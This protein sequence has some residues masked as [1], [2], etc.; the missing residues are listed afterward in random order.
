MCLVVNTMLYAF[1]YRHMV[2]YFMRVGG[3]QDLA[4]RLKLYIHPLYIGA[5]CVV[6][7][8]RAGFLCTHS[9]I[10]FTY[11]LYITLVQHQFQTLQKCFRCFMGV[12]RLC[13]VI[14]SY[15]FPTI[16]TTLILSPVNDNH[17]LVN[18][19]ATCF[20]CDYSRHQA[21]V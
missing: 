10:I 20:G 6:L 16:N 12:I 21:N 3:F 8:L 5:R 17:I 18:R 19:M 9:L 7:Y 13:F 2:H 14:Q 4:L 11:T 1:V 15:L